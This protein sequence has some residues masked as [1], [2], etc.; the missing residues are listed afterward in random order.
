MNRP[1]NRFAT[2]HLTTG[3]P[4]RPE[5]GPSSA[6]K[7]PKVR[8]SRRDRCPFAASNRFEGLLLARLRALEGREPDPPRLVW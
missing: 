1:R 3:S 4:T 6:S 2:D 8:L 7:D 5:A